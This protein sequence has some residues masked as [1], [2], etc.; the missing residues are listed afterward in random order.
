MGVETEAAKANLSESRDQLFLRF[1]DYFWLRP[2]Q[3]LPLV[4]RAE[5]LSRY[6]PALKAQS[7]DVS[8]GDGAFSFISLGGSFDKNSDAFNSVNLE[9][10]PHEGGDYYDFWQP[11]GRPGLARRP[12]RKFSVGTDWKPNLLSKARALGAHD[13]L[14][15]ADNTTPLPF[16]AES[17]D[18]IYANSAYWVPNLRAHLVD[19]AEKLKPGGQLI[20]SMKTKNAAS[21]AHSSFGKKL[22]RESLDFLGMGRERQWQSLW[23]KSA[24]D[25]ELENVPGLQLVKCEPLWGDDMALIWDFGLRPI[26][27]PMAKMSQSMSDA[28]RRE[29]KAEMVSVANR[30]FSHF[31]SNYQPVTGGEIEWTYVLEKP[32]T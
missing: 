2:E 30:I 5:S 29:V 27:S 26:F 4:L 7:L 21:L 10:N 32:I 13:N 24:V 1:L 16:P 15:A 25:L 8:C 18:F 17:F 19:L 20:L 11:Q 14:V 6:F 22:G 12:S 3:A 31:V 23:Q 28:E 9:V